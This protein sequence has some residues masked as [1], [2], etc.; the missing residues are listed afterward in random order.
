LL[1][2]TTA[3][4][5]LTGTRAQWQQDWAETSYRIQAMRDNADCAAQEFALN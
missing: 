3:Q 4:A 1:S 5:V 2:A